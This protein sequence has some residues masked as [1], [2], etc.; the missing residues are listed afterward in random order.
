MKASTIHSVY[1]FSAVLLFLWYCLPGANVLGQVQDIPQ[2]DKS[3]PLDL[4]DPA[5]FVTFIVVPV[6][7]LLL[8]F[9]LRRR[10]R[11]R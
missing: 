6:L 3:E 1:R 9:W 2:A 8:F 10:K 4:Q 5:E 7:L 11:K